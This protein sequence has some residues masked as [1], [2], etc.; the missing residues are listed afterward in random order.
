MEEIAYGTVLG[1]MLG[2]CITLIG[3][4]VYYGGW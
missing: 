3:F 2:I 4:I 1:I